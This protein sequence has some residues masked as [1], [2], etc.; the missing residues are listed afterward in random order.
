[1][2]NHL[3]TPSNREVVVNFGNLS[4]GVPWKTDL[5][6]SLTVLIDISMIGTCSP[7]AQMCRVADNT[8]CLYTLLLNSLSAKISVL[9]MPLVMYLDITFFSLLEIL[10]VVLLSNF[11]MVI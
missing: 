10:P 5:A 11:W 9:V 2:L 1:M 7:L 3:S 8:N 4:K 6:L